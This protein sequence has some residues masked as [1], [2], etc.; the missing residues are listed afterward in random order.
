MMS[1]EVPGFSRPMAGPRRA[2]W[3]MYGS[4]AFVSAEVDVFGTAPGMFATQ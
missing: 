4:V 3:R 1:A 2:I